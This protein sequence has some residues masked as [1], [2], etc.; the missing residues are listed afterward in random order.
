MFASTKEIIQANRF[1][2]SELLKKRC[3]ETDWTYIKSPAGIFTQ[4]TLPYDEIY[5]QLM[6]DTLNARA[7][8]LYQL[9][10]GKLV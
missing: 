3:E 9:Q 5:N 6:N 2:N 7:P 4:A 8:D 10:A 1:E